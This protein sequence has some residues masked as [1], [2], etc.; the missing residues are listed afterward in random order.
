MGNRCLFDFRLNVFFETFP[1]S[2][3][4]LISYSGGARE[5]RVGHVVCPLLLCDFN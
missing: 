2:D 5:T 3:K 1:Q 4:Y